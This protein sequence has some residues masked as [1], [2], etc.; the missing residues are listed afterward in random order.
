M[1]S[2]AQVLLLHVSLALTTLTGIVFAVM[3]YG[4]KSDDPFSV[5]NHPMQPTM[6]AA[7]VVIAP[8]A[9]FALGWAFGNH[10]WPAFRNGAEKKRPSGIWSMLA[11]APM[12]L[13]GY[14]LQVSTAEELRK[15]MAAAHWLTSAF[16]VVVF[17]IHVVLRRQRS[18]E[19]P[20]P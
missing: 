7:H 18:L 20:S 16:F 4:M 19:S 3:R 2:R 1:M 10:M 13:S 12:V 5:V 15:A 6:L 8:L 9:V 11:V 17:T 14:L